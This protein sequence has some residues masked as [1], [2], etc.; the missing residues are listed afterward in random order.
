MIFGTNN[1]ISRCTG[2]SL[3]INQTTIEQVTSY[4][5]LGMM[6]DASLNFESHA[7]K[8]IQRTIV[9]LTQLRKMTQAALADYKS[10][11]L[12]I[13]EY[14]NIFLSSC[15]IETK[16]QLQKLQDKALKC[17]LN[18]DIHAHVNTLHKKAKLNRLLQRWDKQTILFLHSHAQSLKS[19]E[20]RITTRSSGKLTFPLKKPRTEKFKNSISYKGKRMWNRLDK[21]LHTTVDFR[22]FKH[23]IKCIYSE[24]LKKLVV[25]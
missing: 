5:Y 21:E 18:E 17:A 19:K 2:K 23:K 9:K 10:M 3:T 20:Q 22:V 6:L 1:Q 7:Q 11:L 15:K 13:L 24:K 14:G 12:P 25:V 4:T 16:R 8:L